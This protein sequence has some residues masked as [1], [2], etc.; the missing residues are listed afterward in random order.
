MASLRTRC[1]ND[2]S[3]YHAV[4]CMPPHYVDPNN[5]RGR[6]YPEKRNPT[7][8]T[9]VLMATLGA[10]AALAAGVTWNAPLASADTPYCDT[11]P[12]KAAYDCNCGANF[13]PGS[14]EFHDCLYG[15]AV[16]T[17]KP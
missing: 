7:M 1:S 4:L 3:T 10:V 2:G 14:Q 5:K 6:M 13:E 11:L 12:P 9:R 15:N 17:P 16:P 8:K